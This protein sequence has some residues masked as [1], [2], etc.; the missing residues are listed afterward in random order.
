[1]PQIGINWT[2]NSGFGWGTFG[3]EIALNLTSGG[4]W[5]PVL[6]C[7]PGE[8]ACDP[9]RDLLLRSVL[10]RSRDT[11][12]RL[13]AARSGSQITLDIPLF[14]ALGNGASPVFFNSDVRHVGRWNA[15]LTFLE[16]T[17]L[18]QR[19]VA[20]FNG[21]DKVIAGSTWGRD[22]LRSAGVDNVE[23]CLQGVN[24]AT[25]HPAPS[26]RP[27]GDRF[28]IFSGGKFE[29]RKGQD[30]VVAAF[31]VF[32]ERHPESILIAVWGNPWATS[33]GVK[34]F[35]ASRLIAGPPPL[36]GGRI[37]WD[38]FIRRESLPAA[39]L[40]LFETISHLR[41]AHLI[42]EC[43]VALFPNRAEGGTNLVAMEAMACGVPTILSANTG[44][45]DIIGRDDCIPLRAQETVD[46]ACPE[47]GTDGW[48]EPDVEEMVEALESVYQDR[49]RAS[50]IGVRGAASLAAFSWRRQIDA[51]MAACGLAT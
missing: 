18:K 24:S 41:V 25:F 6:L 37:D 13:L 44:H 8:I 51:L 9:L 4:S 21:F 35:E 27:L 39:S 28:V 19:Q 33:L 5:L 17:S 14:H 47:F 49:E 16:N 1:M 43:N 12:E 45:L 48:G 23:V 36:S 20:R 7:E 40:A 30:A 3:L 32:N 29:Y 11:R 50:D 34:Q 15:A 10:D 2:V 42:R 38:T 26:L 22:I 31:K 46:L